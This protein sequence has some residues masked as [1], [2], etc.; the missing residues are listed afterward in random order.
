[1]TPETAPVTPDE[2]LVRLVWGTFY[3]ATDRVAVRPSAFTPKP[4]ESDGISVFRLA[5]LPSAEA[6]LEVIAPAKRGKYAVALVPAAAVFALGMT[7]APAPISTVPG[8]AV[9]PELNCVS[10]VADADR[11]QDVKFQLATLATANVV[12]P[13]TE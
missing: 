7:V 13:P 1:V 2:W 10:D 4:S 11:L 5:C 8:H 9:I 12:R 6:A 3:K